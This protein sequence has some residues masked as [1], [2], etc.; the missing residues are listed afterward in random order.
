MYSVNS[1]NTHNVLGPF[2]AAGSYC[3]LAQTGSPREPADSMHSSYSGA[4]DGSN[5]LIRDR[6]QI[7]LRFIFS[8]LVLVFG[9][10]LGLCV[11]S[12]L[13]FVGSTL[14]T[15]QSLQTEPVIHHGAA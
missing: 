7:T 11:D 6:N 14:E 13:W 12:T 2:E 3:E 1:L 4:Q 9:L 15:L 5:R 8:L 10:F